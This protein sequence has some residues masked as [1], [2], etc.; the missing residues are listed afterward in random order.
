MAGIY[1]VSVPSCVLRLV[2]FELPAGAKGGSTQTFLTAC[3]DMG[4]KEEGNDV[5]LK[6]V[7][8]QKSKLDSDSLLQTHGVVRVIK[9]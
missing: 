6:A 4:Q 8:N 5:A 1:E 2:C 7:N 3:A 9:C